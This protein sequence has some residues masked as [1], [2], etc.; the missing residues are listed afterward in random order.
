MVDQLLVE[1][2][3]SCEYHKYPKC[4]DYVDGKCELRIADLTDQGK[5]VFVNK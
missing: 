1:L 3:D 4:N 5:V 2:L